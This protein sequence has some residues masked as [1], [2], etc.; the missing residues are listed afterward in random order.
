MEERM[1]FLEE[2]LN[3]LLDQPPRNQTSPMKNQTTYAQILQ[4][5]PKH[6]MYNY[7]RERSL[8]NGWNIQQTHQAVV[9]QAWPDQR[10]INQQPMAF[11]NSY[12]RP[13][14]PIETK[15]NNNDQIRQC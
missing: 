15:T 1:T 5:Q 9:P 12:I 11:E 6:Q 4:T 8:E 3:K 14:Y 13:P 7:E 2:R 10:I